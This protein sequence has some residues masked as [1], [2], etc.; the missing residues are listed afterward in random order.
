MGYP[1][2]DTQHAQRL[3]QLAESRHAV[4]TEPLT[5]LLKP[6]AAFT[7]CSQDDRSAAIRLLSSQSPAAGKKSKPSDF[8]YKEIHAGLRSVVNGQGERGVA[9][10]LIQMLLSKGANVNVSREGMSPDE[11]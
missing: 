6:P 3:Q 4:I 8:N 7:T 1:P 2:S 5:A 10:A 9:V 11:R